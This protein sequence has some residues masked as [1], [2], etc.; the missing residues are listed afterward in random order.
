VSKRLFNFCAGP[1]A[2]PEAVLQRAQAELLDWQGKGLSV[3]E[4]SHRSDEFVAIAQQAEQDLRDLLV[5]PDNYKVLF[6]QGGASQQFAQIPLNL[7][8]EGGSADYIDTG[9]WSRKAIDEASRF[10][11][12]NVAGSAKAY[13]YFAIP[14]QNEWQLSAD[15]A[16]V[17][18]CPNETIGGLEF[19]WVPQTGDV[20]LVADM[21]STI[22]SRPIDVSRFGMIYAGA[23]KNIGPSGLVV[24]IVREDLL[25]RARAS[26]PTMLDYA[27]AA[28]ND[29]M[30]NTPPTFAWY[31]SGLIFQWL[32]EQGGLDAVKR[33][34][35][36]KQKALYSA[37]DGSELYN[38]P[39]NVADRSWMNIP[40]RLADDRLDKPFLAGA[41]ERGLLNL[42]GH[43]SVGGMRASI[44]NA[45]PQAAVDALVA[46][47]AEFEQQHG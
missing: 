24:V 41:E 36:A 39:I 4:M 23:Q 1:A 28:Q 11:N 47:M 43:R 37:I 15:A 22:L 33:I 18:Y 8:P 35:D 30:Y 12:V 3:M 44:Y 13:D 21:S 16:Y 6:L 25:G 10:G 5:I 40:F 29:S 42:K 9:I 19:N 14:G 46:Y 17:H 20:P 7:M 32:K 38:N 27:V 26:C 45:V 2:L 34:N 31:L